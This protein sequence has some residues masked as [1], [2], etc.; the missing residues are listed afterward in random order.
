KS[1][2]VHDFKEVQS[3]AEFEDR[4]FMSENMGVA[5]WDQSPEMMKMTVN[6]ITSFGVSHIVPHGINLN[7]SLGTI[8]FPADWYTE[9][10][11]WPYLHQWAD[12][13]RRAS[14]VTRQT[15]LVADVL[16][17]HPLES[18]WGEAQGIF[19][20]HPEDTINDHNPE[21]WSETAHTINQVYSEVMEQLSTNN[22]DF[23]IGDKHYMEQAQLI[24][25]NNQEKLDIL[26]HKFSTLI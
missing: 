14:F 16:L 26:G 11:Y 4:P 15:K 21:V 1:Q 18:I 17:F 22:I 2:K 25:E 23:L 9:N 13:S 19:Y 6:S 20:D 3:V 10:P 12:F 24:E 5:G 7:R 8:P